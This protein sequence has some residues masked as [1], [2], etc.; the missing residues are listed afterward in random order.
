MLLIL[1]GVSIATLTGN[2]GILTQANV[3]KDRTEEANI[4]EQLSI[5]VLGRYM[6]NKD[7]SI[8]TTKENII[9]ELQ[10]EN[11]RENILDYY[12]IPE[13]NIAIIIIEKSKKY[14]YKIDGDTGTVERDYEIYQGDS[15]F[16][17]YINNSISEQEMDEWLS[18]LDYNET[19][20]I[21]GV[22][23]GFFCEFLVQSQSESIENIGYITAVDVSR[24]LN[25]GVI[26]ETGLTGYVLCVGYDGKNIE[27]APIIYSTNDYNVPVFGEVKKGW[28]GITM[29][30]G[31]T[32]KD[33][34][35]IDV[36][37][38]L[39]PGIFAWMS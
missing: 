34:S 5:A 39:K 14:F 18:G 19:L 10:K 24:T 23:G 31:T 8:N 22:K 20:D 6:S 13:K 33:Y 38:N 29:I 25:N 1:A 27:S 16:D 4:Y 17:L 15:I 11:F 21:N 28:K 26:E 32:Y 37:N 2:N 36:N 12:Y 30:E 35:I 9:S 3:A 7:F